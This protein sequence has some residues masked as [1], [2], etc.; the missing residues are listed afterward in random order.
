MADL[1]RQYD[2]ATNT[3]KQLQAQMEADCAAAAKEVKVDLARFTLRIWISW[4][5]F[6]SPRRRWRR[7]IRNRLRAG[8]RGFRSCKGI[9]F[10]AW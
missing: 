3:I 4:R 6:P 1:L 5:S 7:Q 9:A 10:R 2:A 8:T